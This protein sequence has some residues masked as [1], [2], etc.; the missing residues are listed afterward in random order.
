[1]IHLNILALIL[2]TAS[3]ILNFLNWTDGAKDQLTII[4][5]FLGVIFI[6]RHYLAI[7]KQTC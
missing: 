6:P 2:W 1:M 7:L 5:I 4:F 3:T